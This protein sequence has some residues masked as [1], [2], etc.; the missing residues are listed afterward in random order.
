RF[1]LA[2]PPG[3]RWI[4]V[5][6][7]DWQRANAPEPAAALQLARVSNCAG[8]LIDTWQK[9][10]TGLRDWSD[11]DTLVNLAR[12]ARESGMLFA[13]AGRISQKD[14]PFATSIRPDII[15]VRGAVCAA[16]QR[17]GVVQADAV[18]CLK[19]RIN[20]GDQYVPAEHAPSPSPLPLP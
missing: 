18:R 15:G 13:L 5:A 1:H 20:G 9:D 6:Y 12:T 7:A 8:L 19:A 4:L 14:L 16:G 3:S 10:D 11:Y 17:T 2:N